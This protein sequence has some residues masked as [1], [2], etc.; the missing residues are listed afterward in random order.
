MH[1]ISKKFE[2]IKISREPVISLSSTT[3]E[4]LLCGVEV[5]IEK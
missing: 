2:E 3:G 5:K 4:P 1:M